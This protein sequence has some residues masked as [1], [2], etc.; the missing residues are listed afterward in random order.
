MDIEIDLRERALHVI[1]VENVMGGPDTPA[2]AIGVVLDGYRRRVGHRPGDL[3]VAAASH[4]VMERVLFELPSWIRPCHA[5]GGGADAADRWLLDHVD[6]RWAARRVGRVV[7]ASGDA[8]FWPL[9]SSCRSAGVRVEV[10]S[11]GRCLSADLDALA[12]TVHV[13]DDPALALAA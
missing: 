13:L 6:V 11:I 9:A 1:D 3:V 2:S 4:W 8:G 12:D 10:A 5:A 7:V